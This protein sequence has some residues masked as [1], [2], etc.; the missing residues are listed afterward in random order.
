MEMYSFLVKV[1]ADL[2]VVMVGV[3]YDASVAAVGTKTK[4]AQGTIL[5][6][7]SCPVLPCLVLSFPVLSCLV[8]SCLVVACLVLF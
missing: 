6:S 5:I 1:E 8:L 2:G 4:K 3:R 7:S